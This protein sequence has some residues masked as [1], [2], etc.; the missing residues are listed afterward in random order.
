LAATVG[1]NSIHTAD[2]GNAD[3]RAERQLGSSSIDNIPYDLMA[4]DE[5]L[6][7]RRQVAFHDVEVR[8]ADPAGANPKEKLTSCGFRL[9]KLLNVKG[10]FR[11]SEDGGF[12]WFDPRL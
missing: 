2:P 7:S 1:T 6:L 5:R 8:T 3:A 9:G 4:R 11:C 10:R 12:Q